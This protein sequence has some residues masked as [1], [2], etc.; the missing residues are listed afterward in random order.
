MVELTT[1]SIEFNKEVR[2]LS[3]FGD[4]ENHNVVIRLKRECT[5]SGL[6]GI[7]RKFKVIALF[8]DNKEDFKK[9]IESIKEH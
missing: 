4:L 1:K 3:P 8:V 5:L 9:Q 7:S 2:K 6:Y